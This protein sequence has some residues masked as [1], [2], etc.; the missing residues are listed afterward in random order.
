MDLSAIA[1]DNSQSP[2]SALI[3][4]LNHSLA[5]VIL[6]CLQLGKDNYARFT[7]EVVEVRCSVT[8]PENLI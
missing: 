8:S 2:Y 7:D 4:H 3:A 6:P 5:E 1:S